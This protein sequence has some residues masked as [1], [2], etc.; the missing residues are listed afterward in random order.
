MTP[1]APIEE[2]VVSAPREMR[3]RSGSF[4]N[5]WSK[6]GG[7]GGGTWKTGDELKSDA[8]GAKRASIKV[9]RAD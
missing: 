1:A 6:K 5:V 2:E 7:G 8:E 4:N 9:R 3:A